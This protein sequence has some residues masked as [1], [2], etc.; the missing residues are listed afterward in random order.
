MDQRAAQRSAVQA[1][2]HHVRESR[3]HTALQ[4]LIGRGPR[5]HVQSFVARDAEKLLRQRGR[6]PRRER[7]DPERA[8]GLWIEIALLRE[9]QR[10][11]EKE[12][13]AARGFAE[14]FLARLFHHLA[15]RAAEQIAALGE[16]RD[17][18][19]GGNAARIMR[20]EQHPRVA[21]MR[22]KGEHAAAQ[23]SDSRGANDSAPRF[24][25]RWLPPP[26]LHRAQ[27]REQRLGAFQGAGLRRFQPAKLC[28]VLHA[29]RLQ[30]QDDLG[31]IEPLHFRQFLRGPVEVLALRP[32][33]HAA[34]RR[35]ASRPARA[36]VRARPADLLD[37]QRIDAAIRIESRHPRQT[38]ID[39]QPH[40]FDGQRGLGHVRRDDHLSLLVA[41][42]RGV[43]LGGGQ[44][45]V[46]RQHQ[47]LAAAARLA[48]RGDRAADLVSARHKDERVSFALP[49]QPFKL[50]GGGIPDRRIA[51]RAREVFHVHGKSAPARG[52]EFARR[53][54]RLERARVQ[55][56]G[57]DDEAQ[58]RALASPANPARA[59][60]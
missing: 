52:Q 7:I 13:I 1:H 44:F 48:D 32:Q 31:E 25:P 34:A 12:E 53:Q 30:G 26:A 38:A 36:L 46:Q 23:R 39:H 4:R 28:H 14:R 10:A 21:G 58:I 17:P 41:R 43:L 24:R 22:G 33:A 27:I 9:I 55:R 16:R 51:E 50:R 29:A 40:A 6:F 37:E 42:H 18:R 11:Q 19:R 47:T 15:F 20:R 2:G 45:A 3:E 49:G 59:P 57:H 60:A 5:L 56:R 35:G 8:A 54:I